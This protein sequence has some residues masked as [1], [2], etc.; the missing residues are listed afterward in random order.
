VR[1]SSASSADGRIE[2]GPMARRWPASPEQTKHP[3]D[4]RLYQEIPILRSLIN[5]SA[6]C[7]LGARRPPGARPAA[8]PHGTARPSRRSADRLS[9]AAA[10]VQF[11]AAVYTDLRWPRSTSRCWPRPVTEFFLDS[12][13]SEALGHDDPAVVAPD[14]LVERVADR[15]LLLNHGREISRI[16]SGP[17][18]PPRQSPTLRLTLER[19]EDAAALRRSAEVSAAAPTCLVRDGA[20]TAPVWPGSSRRC[21]PGDWRRRPARTTCLSGVRRHA[22]LA[23][24]TL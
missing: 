20:Q 21:R 11:I 2:C 4:R 9:K 6:G 24:R 8:R 22:R 17:S 13:A 7:A 3:E 16:R 1:M 14:G 23:G 5:F 10:E 19:A 18:P 15:V 12:S